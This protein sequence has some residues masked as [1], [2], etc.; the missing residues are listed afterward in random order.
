[1]QRLVSESNAVVWQMTPIIQ[2]L[3]TSFF[4]GSLLYG[5]IHRPS[6]HNAQWTGFGYHAVLPGQASYKPSEIVTSLNVTFPVPSWKKRRFVEDAYHDLV[7]TP[8]LERCQ[9]I[10]NSKKGN[11][12]HRAQVLNA[13]LP[14]A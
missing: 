8:G 9:E 13:N 3:C 4:I 12:T 14:L 7:I 6:A 5:C 10:N 11:K 2:D 1:M